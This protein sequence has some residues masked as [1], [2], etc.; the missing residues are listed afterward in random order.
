M[1]ER[2]EFVATLMMGGVFGVVI[3]IG[4][5]QTALQIYEYKQKAARPR[6]P[7]ET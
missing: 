2:R 7:W 4:L 5:G 3:L 1:K 6:Q